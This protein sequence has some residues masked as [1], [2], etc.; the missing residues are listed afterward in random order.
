MPVNADQYVGMRETSFQVQP[1]SFRSGVDHIQILIYC[2]SS[3]LLSKPP[4]PHPFCMQDAAFVVMRH[5]EHNAAQGRDLGLLLLSFSRPSSTF[6]FLFLLGEGDRGGR[7]H[8]QPLHWTGLT[9]K[10]VF[11]PVDHD[12]LLENI[13]ELHPVPRGPSCIRLLLS[14]L[15]FFHRHY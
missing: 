6:L 15:S 7:P 8:F 14:F 13:G 11:T 3:L 5:L 4:R 12:P 1:G 2:G 9:Q 10:R